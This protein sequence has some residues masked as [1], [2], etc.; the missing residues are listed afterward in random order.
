VW[1]H[2]VGPLSVSITQGMSFFLLSF[3][4]SLFFYFVLVRYAGNVIMVIKEGCD[5]T[6]LNIE[7]VSPIGRIFLKDRSKDD[8]PSFMN[9]QTPCI[10]CDERDDPQL[11]Q[12]VLVQVNFGPRGTPTEGQTFQNLIA[13]LPQSVSD[14][15]LVQHSF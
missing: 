6:N 12:S 15:G 10:F 2:V 13:S 5:S 11:F 1:Q 14:L 9:T 3:Y 8:L 4:F 7:N